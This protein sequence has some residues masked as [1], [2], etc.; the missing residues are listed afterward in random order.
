MLDQPSVSS[1][2]NPHATH[3]RKQHLR[4]TSRAETHDGTPADFI[5]LSLAPYARRSLPN[6]GLMSSFAHR[7]PPGVSTRFLRIERDLRLCFVCRLLLSWWLPHLL[8][9]KHTAV[10]KNQAFCCKPYAS[11]YFLPAFIAF[12]LYTNQKIPRTRARYTSPNRSFP[13][14]FQVRFAVFRL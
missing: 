2:T 14:F 6:T 1:Q 13:H 4:Q 12:V 10:S 7:Q 11:L 5:F 3:A 9:I 8:H